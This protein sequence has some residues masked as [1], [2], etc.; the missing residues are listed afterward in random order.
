M[1]L[2]LFQSTMFTSLALRKCKKGKFFD[3]TE[4]YR[5]PEISNFVLKTKTNFVIYITKPKKL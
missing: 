1:F 2:V 5:F 4:I 3:K